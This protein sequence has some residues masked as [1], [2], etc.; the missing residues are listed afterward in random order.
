M[1]KYICT[2]CGHIYDPEKGEPRPFVTILCNTDN[3]ERYECRPTAAYVK[4]GTDF[5][6][7]PSDWKCPC[8][9]YLKSYYRKKV[10]DTLH[11]MR[12]I[13]Y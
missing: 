9:G 3:I 8:C 4:A 12:T 11:A 13:S 1:D 7:L 10:Q 5:P 2:M 6:S